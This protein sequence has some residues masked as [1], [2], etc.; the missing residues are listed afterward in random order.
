MKTPTTAH[1]SKHDFERLY[2]PAE[3]TFLLL[4]TLE[5]QLQKILGLEP[6]F[7]LEIGS[8]S[9]LP[10]TH[11]GKLIGPHCIYHTTDINPFACL[12]TA[13]TGFFNNVI[14]D[15]I[16]TKFAQG[17]RIQYDV[18]LFNP[19]YVVTT[20][21]AKLND[22]EA[23]WAGGIDGREVIDEFI[24]IIGKLIRKGGVLYLVCINEN[25]PQE[26]IELMTDFVGSD[27]KYRVVG[28]EGLHVLEFIKIKGF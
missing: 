9:G 28:W 15:S 26:I 11:L 23:S 14:I 2:E 7:C 12:K 27:V 13:E 21:I 6:I 10:I 18:V 24:K 20:N 5:E 1:I 3:D 19:P 16:N 8:G 17:I 22:L 4:D 25:K